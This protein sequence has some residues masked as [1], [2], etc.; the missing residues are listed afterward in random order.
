MYIENEWETSRSW[1]RE[2]MGISQGMGFWDE[3]IIILFKDGTI[4]AK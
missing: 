3:L 2:R 4:G 1:Q